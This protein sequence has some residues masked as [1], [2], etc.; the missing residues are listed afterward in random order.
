MSYGTMNVGGGGEA[1][2]STTT[3]AHSSHLVVRRPRHLVYTAIFPVLAALFA[4]ASFV[5]G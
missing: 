1:P 2:W 3:R 5:V 4:L